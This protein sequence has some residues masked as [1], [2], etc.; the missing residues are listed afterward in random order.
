M[1]EKINEKW[2]VKQAWV[3]VSKDSYE[4][5]EGDIVTDFILDRVVNKQYDNLPCIVSMV[6]GEMGTDY[7]I[8]DYGHNGSNKYPEIFTD[9]LVDEDWY[10]ISEDFSKYKDWV[11]GK[12]NLYSAYVAI[13]LVK[14]IERNPAEE[15]FTAEG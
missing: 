11:D 9:I 2:L 10:H 8:A 12:I 15:E 1:N 13:A 3:S 6:N 4:N 5:G 14:V 7:T